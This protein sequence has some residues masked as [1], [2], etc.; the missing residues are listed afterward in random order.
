MDSRILSLKD[1]EIVYDSQGKVAFLSP[2]V[3]ADEL[4]K[5]SKTGKMSNALKRHVKNME[6]HDKQTEAERKIFLEYSSMYEK[7]RELE[8]QSKPDEA[9]DLYLDILAYYNPKGTAYYE[10]PCIILE[11]QK[12]YEEAIIICKHAIEAIDNKLFNADVGEFQHRLNR[13][14]RKKNS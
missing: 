9:L 8:R 4:C 6:E 10:R 1:K 3:L 14:T 13:L 5:Y 2:E 12:R 7:A 11:K